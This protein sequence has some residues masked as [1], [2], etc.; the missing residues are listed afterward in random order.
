M[1][2][3]TKRPMPASEVTAVRIIKWGCG[4]GFGLATG[5]I[6]YA[7]GW[8]PGL[9]SML[10]SLLAIFSNAAAQDLKEGAS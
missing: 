7:Y 2:A 8:G 9:V 5:W 6:F 3:P 4:A 1:T 10:A